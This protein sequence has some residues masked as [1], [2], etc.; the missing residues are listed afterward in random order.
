MAR[1]RGLALLA[2]VVALGSCSNPR[3]RIDRET[4]NQVSICRDTE[5]ADFQEAEDMAAEFCGRRKL[6]PRLAGTD[7][8]TRRAVRY[9]YI[10]VAPR[11]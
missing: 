7:R 2:V 3:L 6:L 9:N 4:D 5:T 8:C 10:C 1:C 11:Y